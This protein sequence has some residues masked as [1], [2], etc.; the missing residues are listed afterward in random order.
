MPQRIIKKIKNDRK[1][2]VASMVLVGI[3]VVAG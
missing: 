3:I 2:Q 1:W